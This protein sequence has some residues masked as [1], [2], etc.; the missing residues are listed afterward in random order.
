M[1][2]LKYLAR[3]YAMLGGR[4]W[5]R[6]ICLCVV[7]GMAAQVEFGFED[8]QTL[9]EEQGSQ[10]FKAA[11][12]PVDSARLNLTDDPHAFAIGAGSGKSH[13]RNLQCATFGR[14]PPE[15]A[16]PVRFRAKKN[17]CLGRQ[18]N[19]QWFKEFHN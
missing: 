11:S 19:T 1:Y 10:P 6:L 13:S 17:C 7:F 4:K 9:A 15:P 12:S 5:G 16:Q 18:P 3:F 8:V 14:A 2:L